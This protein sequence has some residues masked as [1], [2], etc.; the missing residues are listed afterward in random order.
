MSIF[1]IFPPWGRTISC[2][3]LWKQ[4]TSSIVFWR[5]SWRCIACNIPNLL[6]IKYTYWSLHTA[7]HPCSTQVNRKA[8][9]FLS[10][11]FFLH[12]TFHYPLILLSK[13]HITAKSGFTHKNLNQV[14]RN[15][16]PYHNGILIIPMGKVCIFFGGGVANAKIKQE[17]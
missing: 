16:F 9:T 11:F 3:S 8:N 12:I 17:N 1:V 13:T 14:I 2:H 15:I 4:G 10:S 6:S 5:C 7:I